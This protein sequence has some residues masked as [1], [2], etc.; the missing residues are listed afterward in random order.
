MRG[1]AAAPGALA[2][3]TLRLASPPKS[4]QSQERAWTAFEAGPGPDAGSQDGHVVGYSGYVSGASNFYGMSFGQTTTAAK[5]LASPT[6]PNTPAPG[7]CDSP[8]NRTPSSPRTNV[9]GYGGYLKGHRFKYA[10]TFG[11]TVAELSSE[12]S[13]AEQVPSSGETVRTQETLTTAEHG[14]IPGYAGFV[15]SNMH[16]YGTTYGESSRAALATGHRFREGPGL[17]ED[18]S[19]AQMKHLPKD[20][21]EAAPKNR[22]ENYRSAVSLD[23][24][25]VRLDGPSTSLAGPF[26]L[27]PRV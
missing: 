25:S 26:P 2:L 4:A 19:L 16:Y 22:F 3:P 9:P 12:A 20:G 10:N 1:E 6:K 18:E 5:S 11:N 13:A 27:D 24:A 14:H 17:A 8:R 21:A 15:R 7:G 23:G